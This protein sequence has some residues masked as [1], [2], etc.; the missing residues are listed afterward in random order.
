MSGIEQQ[1]QVSAARN[2]IESV[3]IARSAP[4]VN[5]DDACRAGRNHFLDLRRIEIVR[6]RIDI[7]EHRR[8]LLPLK[9]VGCGDER[10]GRNNHFTRQTQSPDGNFQR[11]R[12]IAHRNAV[13]HANKLGDSS[14]EILY[15]WAIIGK[16]IAVKHVIDSLLEAFSTANIW[17]ANVYLLRKRRGFSEDSEVLKLKSLV[18]LRH[19]AHIVLYTTALM[20]VQTSNVDSTGA[21]EVD[22]SGATKLVVIGS[23][24]HAAVLID[25][26]QLGGAYLIAGYLDDTM[27]RG[28]VRRGHPILGAIEDVAAVCAEHEIRGAVIAIGDNWW[29]RHVHGK[30]IERCPQLKFPTVLHPSAVVSKSAE[31]G[32]GAAVLATCHIGPGS[33]VG[34]FCIL[35]TGSSID[36]DCQMHNFSSIGPGVFTGGLVEIGECS[37][38][39]VGAS[40]SDRISVGRHT[41]VGTGSVVVQDIPDLVVAYGNPARVQRSRPEGEIYVST[42][43][44][45]S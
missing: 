32:S 28:T 34:A 10:E 2:S 36:H 22:P 38:I 15:V 14:L 27:A 13:G 11:Y 29:R 8:N 12:G 33:K 3:N 42:N 6:S 19:Q 23:S 1:L 16:P 44:S 26:I 41:V 21:A 30:L 18:S 20:P 25:A 5:S 40:I 39:G 4:G 17:S 24:G 31:V 37:A 45:S 9:G 43:K 35:N 7:A